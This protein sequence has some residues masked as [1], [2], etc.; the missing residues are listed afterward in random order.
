M[1]NAVNPAQVQKFLA[2]ID[3]PCSKQDLIQTAQDEGADQNVLD[4]L[5]RLPDQKDNSPNDVAGQIGTLT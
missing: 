1:S 5:K 2:G 3:Y 4:T